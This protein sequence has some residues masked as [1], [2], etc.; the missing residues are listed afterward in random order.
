MHLYME[1]DTGKL[2][3][4]FNNT[5][6]GIYAHLCNKFSESVKLINRNKSENV[7]KMQEAKYISTLKRML[8]EAVM[9]TI[10]KCDHKESRE[11]LKGSLTR[12]INYYLQE[13]RLRANSM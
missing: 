9:T 2:Q 11:Q 13:F 12:R 8:E 7:F 4:E 6:A 5:A 3:I 10:E 1:K